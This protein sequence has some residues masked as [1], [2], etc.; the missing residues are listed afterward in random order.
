ML[1]PVHEQLCNETE[2]DF[3]REYLAAQQARFQVQ[4]EAKKQFEE[5][6]RESEAS[7]EETTQDEDDSPSP[8]GKTFHA[9]GKRFVHSSTGLTYCVLSQ[10]FSKVKYMFSG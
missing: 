10:F 2:N 1:S 6:K 5:Q 3:I 8:K 9:A 7:A 4:R